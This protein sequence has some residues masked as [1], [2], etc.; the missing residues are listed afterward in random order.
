MAEPQG[1]DAQ[2]ITVLYNGDCPVCAYEIGTYQKI[3]QREGLAIGWC[4]IMQDQDR[5]EAIGLS[6][7]GGARRLHVIDQ[8]R[9]LITGVDAFQALWQ[10]LP[11]W[12]WL[13]RLVATRPGHF[14]ATL[15][16]EG[17]CAPAL[18][19]LHQWRTKRSHKTR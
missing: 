5:L 15:I 8:H 18:Y 3:A 19:L 7:D 17:L 1:D 14:V 6:L 16:Y 10:R 12:R 2:D 9:R 13:G 4:D 11:G